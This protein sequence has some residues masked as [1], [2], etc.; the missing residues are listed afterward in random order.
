MFGRPEERNE[1]V[2]VEHRVIATPED[3]DRETRSETQG[4]GRLERL[5]PLCDRAEGGLRPVAGAHAGAHLAA[6]LEAP[7]GCGI[8][9]EAH[10]TSSGRLA[11]RRRRGSPALRVK[12]PW[13][14]GT[15]R[16]L[17]V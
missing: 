11:R 14:Y 7:L 3:D 10:G 16:C 17:T 5:R 1:G 9:P 4:Y 8:A 12:S 13:P 15:L 2:V 6:L